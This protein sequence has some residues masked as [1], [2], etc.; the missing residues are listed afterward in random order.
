MIP[1]KDV[2]RRRYSGTVVWMVA[3]F[4]AAAVAAAVLGSHPPIAWWLF[5]TL[6]G[7]IHLAEERPVVPFFETIVH[8]HPLLPRPDNYRAVH[9]RHR[10]PWWTTVAVVRDDCCFC[11]CCIDKRLACSWRVF[12]PHFQSNSQRWIDLPKCLHY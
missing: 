1:R 8:L 6:V 4:E 3:V 9:T 10:L 2:V 5:G 7:E 12:V 11:G